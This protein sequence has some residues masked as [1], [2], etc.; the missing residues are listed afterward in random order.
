MFIMLEIKAETKSQDNKNQVGNKRSQVGNKG[1]RRLETKETKSSAEMTRSQILKGKKFKNY[2]RPLPW[3]PSS[4]CTIIC[5]PIMFPF[6]LEL[7]FCYLLL[8]L[9]LCVHSY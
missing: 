2:F 7:I 3:P 6:K 8:I 9:I 1:G 4:P 5:F